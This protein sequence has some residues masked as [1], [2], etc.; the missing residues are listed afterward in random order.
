[1]PYGYC[2]LLVT[3]AMIMAVQAVISA[4][5]PDNNEQFS[6][7]H[8]GQTPESGRETRKSLRAPVLEI[9]I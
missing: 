4:G 6:F 2:T 9:C 1:M 7:E 8:R 5:L 3:V